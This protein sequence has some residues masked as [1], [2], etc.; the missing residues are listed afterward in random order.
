MACRMG[1]GDPGYHPTR[2]PPPSRHPGRFG[3]APESTSTRSPSEAVYPGDQGMQG[4]AARDELTKYDQ[5]KI[6]NL[7]YQ[8]II[9]DDILSFALT[10]GAPPLPADGVRRTDSRLVP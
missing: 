6:H 5:V 9:L 10:P 2:A 3:L 4:P 1:T 8:V 7:Y